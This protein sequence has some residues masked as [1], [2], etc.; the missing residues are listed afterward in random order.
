MFFFFFFGRGAGK[1]RGKYS[2][3][4]RPQKVAEKKKSPY[5]SIIAGGR[6]PVSRRPFGIVVLVCFLRTLN[7]LYLEL[8]VISCWHHASELDD[9]Q[10]DGLVGNQC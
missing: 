10:V 8:L 2:D 3:L 1:V 5:V 7:F 9:P 4:I 6:D